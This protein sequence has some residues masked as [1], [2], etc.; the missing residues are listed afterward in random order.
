MVQICTVD[1][2]SFWALWRNEGKVAVPEGMS[3]ESRL[4]S[5]RGLQTIEEDG[6]LESREKDA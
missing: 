6:Q 5:L 3:P 2:S 4:E 1:S